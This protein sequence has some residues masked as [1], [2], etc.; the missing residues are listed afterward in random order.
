[1][2]ERDKSINI[3]TGDCLVPSNNEKQ[4]RFN[5][6]HLYHNRSIKTT[7]EAT[8]APKL[9]QQNTTGTA[10]IVPVNEE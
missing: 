9:N 10:G 3:A 1:M 7:A 8:V 2:L 6:L 5:K 4:N